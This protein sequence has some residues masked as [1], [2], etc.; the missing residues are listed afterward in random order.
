MAGL[1]LDFTP[2]DTQQR[3]SLDILK[4]S[5]AHLLS[6][7]N[8]VLDFS[9]V[10]A[11]RLDLTPEP[12]WLSRLVKDSTNIFQHVARQKNLEF[13]V[14]QPRIGHIALFGDST[15]IRQI[16][17]N[18]LGNAF[19]FTHKGFV[20]CTLYVA[21]NN[22][23]AELRFVIEDSGIGIPP[24]RTNQLFQPFSQLDSKRTRV[25]GGTGLGLAIS[26]RLAKLMGGDLFH[27]AEYHP[28]SKFV[29]KITLPQSVAPEEEKSALTKLKADGDI[30]IVDDYAP[31]AAILT[32]L[33]K[34]LGLSAH[35]CA[36]A[37]A[38]LA[39]CRKHV[40]PIIFM[41]VHMP[42]TDGF[43]TARLIREQ[44]PA[45]GPNIPIV[46]LT[47][48]VRT[49]IRKACQEAGMDGFLA[50]PIRLDALRKM[51][52]RFLASG[53]L[54]AVEKPT[55]HSVR[56]ALDAPKSGLDLD[57]LFTLFGGSYEPEL[58]YELNQMF[59]E[60]W[61]ELPVT[62]RLIEDAC[63][64][65]D[66]TTAQS[67]CHKLRGVVSNYGFKLAGDILTKMEHEEECLTLSEHLARLRTVLGDSHR[68][69]LR[70]Y[71]FLKR[72]G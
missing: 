29:F 10:E 41:D 16:L 56:E 26:H 22:N 44:Q 64:A 33:L 48:D 54:S 20:G 34:Q 60:F 28:G 31:N 40:P 61:D 72:R 5:A 1:I 55:E 62:L 45:D 17:V 19:K 70:L 9:R 46:A 50:K 63:S 43:T 51:L 39:Y 37:E 21:L 3:E 57:L 2:L 47:A 58:E 11:G 52:G 36:S 42:V 6:L 32:L 4:T 53:A 66:Q 15:R 38:A 8:D 14:K 13:R 67:Q 49:N 71:P 59:N 23:K 65:G 18:L 69:L 30:L 25:Y 24:D 68:E 12:F 7:L 35:H 27:D